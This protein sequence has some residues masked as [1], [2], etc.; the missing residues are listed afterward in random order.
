MKQYAPSLY[1]CTISVSS[2]LLF[3]VKLS[4]IFIILHILWNDFTY[5]TALVTKENPMRWVG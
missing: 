4:H 1:Y 5:I 2:V 3:S